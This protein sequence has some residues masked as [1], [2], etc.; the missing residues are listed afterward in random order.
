MEKRAQ[1]TTGELSLTSKSPGAVLD[2]NVVL[3]WLLFADPA[4]LA[5]AAAV[6]SGRVRWL[7]TTA[8]RD[9]LASVLAR[10]LAATREVDAAA[11][12]AAWD[13]HAQLQ[14]ASPAQSLRCS[15]P[16]D[17]KFIDLAVA[18]GARWLV[19]RDRAVLALARRAA[20]SGLTILGP[21]QWRLA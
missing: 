18:A 14:A 21:A 10:G 6:M 19:S 3:D 5:L 12:L 1:T 2:T 15:D 7:A 17:Q 11:L 13:A 8:M 4:V 9:E 16:D 20:P